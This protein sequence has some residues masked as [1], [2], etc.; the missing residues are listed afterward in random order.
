MKAPWDGGRGHYAGKP[1]LILGGAASVGQYGVLQFP[2]NSSHTYV[3]FYC[4][5]A[6]QFA[7]LSGF[8][9][10]FTTASLRNTDLLKS[11]GATHVIDRNTPAASFASEIARFTRAPIALVFD[12]VATAETQQL[13]YDVL[14]EGGQIVVV[15]QSSIKETPGSTKK[16]SGSFGNVHAPS[17]R[18]IGRALAQHLTKLLEAGDIV[19]RILVLFSM[20]DESLTFTLRSAEPS[21]GGSRRI[22]RYCS[23]TG[24]TQEQPRQREEVGR[25]CCR[26]GLI[27]SVRL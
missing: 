7:K 3:R 26:D 2:L 20:N 10:I 9:P 18:A 15:L 24:Q 12:A 11:L 21:R 27:V 14:G 25:L 8:S 4:Q 19:V 1:A 17:N 6:I 5:L 13:G 22:E 16:V 23:R